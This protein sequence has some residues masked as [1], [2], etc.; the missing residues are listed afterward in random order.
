MSDPRASD[1]ERD[2]TVDRLRA[3]AAEG[4]LT[5]E[6][7]A[8]RA[9]LVLAAATRGELERI[10]ADLPPAAPPAAATQAHRAVLSSADHGGRWRL[11][12]RNRFVT[13]LGSTTLDLRQAVLPGAEVDIDLRTVLGSVEVLLPAAAEVEVTGGGPLLQRSMYVGPEPPPPGGPVI[14]IHLAGAVGSVTVRD[15]PSLSRQLKERLGIR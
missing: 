5:V 13:V 4:R 11:S 8:Q 14:R 7:L 6:E 10:T 12:P 15:R 9:E 1:A 3:A 2:A